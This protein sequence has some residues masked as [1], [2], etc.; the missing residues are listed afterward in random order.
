[1]VTSRIKPEVS[2]EKTS[3]II[4][5]DLE[6]SSSVY[7]T[8]IL[9]K[10]VEIVLGKKREN[11]GLAYFVGYVVLDN[12]KVR[13]IGI[14]EIENE[15]LDNVLDED[16]DV[17]LDEMKAP[18]LFDNVDLTNSLVPVAE[19]TTPS[20]DDTTP[21]ADDT[22]PSADDTTPSADDTTPSADDTTPSADT[23]PKPYTPLPDANRTTEQSESEVVATG[24]WIQQFMQNKNYSTIDNEGGGDCLFAAI[25][26][27][28]EQIG[29][30]Y[31]VGD[32][33]KI[34]S[35]EV[36]QEVFDN[37]RTLYV[38]FQQSVKE[39]KE[40]LNSIATE[41]NAL[42]EQLPKEQ[43]TKK[44]IEIV[45]KAKKLKSRFTRLKEEL[46]IS[47]AM[48]DEQSFMG[49]VTSLDQFKAKINTCKFW[50]DTWAISTLERVLNTKFILLSEESFLSDDMKNVLQCGQL[51][52]V[53]LQEKG[54]FTPDYYIILD[55][56][57]YHYKLITYK[58]HGIFKFKQL[59]F[60]IRDLIVD[61]C[62]EKCQVLMLSFQSLLQKNYHRR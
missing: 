23:A 46:A 39:T 22:T 40:E 20:A 18:L 55:Y 33:R 45:E 58:D 38:S 27:A 4:D 10:N 42:K 43:N 52:D 34:L 56:N 7:E 31:T 35:K 41:N 59:P 53:I 24:K 11:E 30:Q 60:A 9:G 49:N 28:F 61:K 12:D 29:H 25:R 57:G 37:Y 14:F 54:V 50:G 36:T 2:Y 13:P 44:Q 26:D 19:D 16:G 15:K 17:D 51:N 21:S 1:M 6:H 8:E 62:L 5:E 48:L 32:L 47:K 3:K